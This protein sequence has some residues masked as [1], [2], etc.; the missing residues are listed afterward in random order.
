MQA[1]TILGLV[2]VLGVIFLR[3]RAARNQPASSAKQRFKTVHVLIGAVVVWLVISMNL[4]RLDVSL[5][6]EPQ[7]PQSTWERVVRTLSDWL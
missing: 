5:S 2:L 4:K 1:I 3:A 7:A 6:G